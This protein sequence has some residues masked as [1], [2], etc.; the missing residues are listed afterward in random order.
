[1]VEQQWQGPKTDR[2]A[3]VDLHIGVADG[4]RLAVRN[5]GLI[6]QINDKIDIIQCGECFVMTED[7]T[8]PFPSADLSTMV[9]L[10][11]PSPY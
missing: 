8:N 3:D 7:R 4:L 9:H 10:V 5:M 11:R 2:V 1:M 6:G